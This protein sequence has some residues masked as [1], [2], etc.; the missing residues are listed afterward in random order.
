MI[1]HLSLILILKMPYQGRHT[2]P[3]KMVIIFLPLNIFKI[4]FQLKKNNASA[5]KKLGECYF[6]LN[7]LKNSS[8]MYEKSLEINPE[9]DACYCEYANV[10]LCLGHYDKAL[11]NLNKALAI[12][13]YNFMAFYYKA[14]A[15]SL[16]KD[17]DNAFYY[18]ERA[19]NYCDSLKRNSS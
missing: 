17:F 18:L 3:L 5:Y 7:D 12:S 13:P 15:Y 8:K 1:K 10:L 19:F 14:R 6:L 2:A 11:N 4:L 16:K 9:N